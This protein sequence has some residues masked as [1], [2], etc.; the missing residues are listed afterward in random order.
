MALF[1][2][3]RATP[4]A[5][6]E[7]WRRLTD[8]QRHGQ[9]VPL[10]RVTVA[11]GPPYGKGT[12]FTA[13]SGIGRLAFDDPMEVAV[14]RPPEAEGRAGLCRLVKRGS[15]VTGWAEIEVHGQGGG[16]RVIWREELR[17]HGLPRFLDPVLAR[18]AAWVFGRAAGALLA[19]R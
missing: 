2:V 17:V 4:L 11:G 13:R 6:D 14:W 16:S 3:E 7:A 5:P 15:V 1:R 12:V 10:T 18:V 9:V 19:S 8:W